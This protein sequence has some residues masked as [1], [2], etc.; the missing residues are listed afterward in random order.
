MVLGIK[1]LK[2]EPAFAHSSQSFQLAARTKTL[3]ITLIINF[4]MGMLKML[5][6]LM[7]EK[8]KRENETLSKIKKRPGALPLA[9]N[10]QVEGVG[11]VHGIGE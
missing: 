10:F 1:R 7:K 11:E 4:N 2:V 8:Q 5:S 3:F 6:L 9:W